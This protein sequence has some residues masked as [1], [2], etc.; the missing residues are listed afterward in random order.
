MNTHILFPRITGTGFS[1]DQL[2]EGTWRVE[3]DESK[4]EENQIAA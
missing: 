1:V 3:D 2:S 4:E